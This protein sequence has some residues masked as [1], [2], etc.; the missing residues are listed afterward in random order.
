MSYD[1]ALVI[2]LI[3]SVFA[4]PAAVS[5]FSDGRVPRAAALVIMLGGGLTAWAI[6]QKPSGYTLNEI[7]EV[8]IKVTRDVIG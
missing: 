6:T 5:A 3:I 7:P 1:M 4:I 2:G 8:F